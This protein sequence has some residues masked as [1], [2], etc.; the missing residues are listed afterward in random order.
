M[1]GGTVWYGRPVRGCRAPIAATV[2][3]LVV[4]IA[5]QL[6]AA[7]PTADGGIGLVVFAVDPKARDAQ[8]MVDAVRAHLTGLPVRLV[9]GA[10]SGETGADAGSGGSG[11]VLG[12][13]TIDPAT[14]GE[15]VVSFTEPAIDTTLVRRIRIKPQGKAV[16]LEEAAIVV[17]SMVEAILD[18]GHVGIARPLRPAGE[19]TSRAPAPRGPRRGIAITG[20]Y[21]G[22]AF[23][24]GLGWQSGAQF[25]L[26]WQYGELYAGVAYAIFAPIE[27]TRSGVSLRLSRY[28]GSLVLGY[29]GSS[30]LAPIVEVELTVDHVRRQTLQA[31]GFDPTDSEGRWTLGVGG[32]VGLS[33]SILPRLR[34]LAL[35]GADW[36][37]NSYAYVAPS[38]I[39]V[40][41]SSVRPKVVVG[42]GLDLW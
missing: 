6:G 26:R 31:E 1:D 13:L 4:S 40:P 8:A 11:R 42:L 38:G 39:I 20:G 33:W 30:R 10:D 36:M 19:E 3:S 35:G 5:S 37:V 34:L 23:A 16:A 28:P 25:G 14:P 29:E 24:P 17:R 2:F 15:W 21:F 7:E 9:I 18:G 41:A 12:T 22:T 27:T 32:E